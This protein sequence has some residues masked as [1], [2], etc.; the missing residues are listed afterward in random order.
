[1]IVT[2]YVNWG[3]GV[4]L[5]EKQAEEFVKNE[6]YADATNNE[7]FNEWLSENYSP[8]ELFD[9]DENEKKTIRAEFAEAMETTMWDDFM[10]DGYEE[11]SV[12]I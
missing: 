5:N 4:I 2:L 10:A 3:D 1:M 8:A 7:S 12:E 9:A 11:V 6:Y